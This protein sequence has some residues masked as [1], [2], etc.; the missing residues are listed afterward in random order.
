MD[1]AQFWKL[2]GVVDREALHRFHEEAAA[3]PLVRNRQQR[4]ELG[5]DTN[6]IE[7]AH[8]R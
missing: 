1:R 8:L 2:I 5:V 7:R 6:A 4:R 3:Q